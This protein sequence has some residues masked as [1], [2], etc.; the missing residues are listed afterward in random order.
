MS[1]DEVIQE[2]SFLRF[3]LNPIWLPD[4]VTYQLFVNNLVSP[5]LGEHVCKVSPRSVQPFRRI[6]FINK[7]NKQ[8]YGCR[9][10]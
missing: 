10:T 1:I 9:T 7:S 4:H 2:K 6:F 8:Q 3:S 5:R